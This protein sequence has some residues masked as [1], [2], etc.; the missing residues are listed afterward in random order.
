MKLL[1]IGNGGREHAL[2]WKLAQSPRVW[3]VYVAPGNAG[4]VR[5]HKLENIAITAIPD[6]I[7]FSRNENIAFT[8]VGPE[9]PLAE[10]IV[11]AY[12]AA[13]LKIFGPTQKAAQLE[14]SKRFAKDFMQR[15]NI[16]TAAYAT[17]TQAEAAHQYVDQQGTPIVIKASGL[18]AGKGVIVATTL[19][20][21]HAAINDILVEQRFGN[22][23]TEV[24]IEEFLQ[25]TEV[26]FIVMSD[27]QH[28]L[29]LATSQDH[30][31]LLDGDSG[32]NT[33]GMGAYSPTPFV[34][35][36]L[37]A[38]IMSKVIYPVI[39]GM[40]HEGALYT[41]FLYAGLMITPDKQIKVLEFNC[42]MGDPE[43]QPIMLRLKSDLSMLMERAF[44]GALD[45]TETEW[46]R[47]VALGV[48]MV[49]GGYPENPAKGD[50]IR[51]LAELV[52]E[53]DVAG[54][55]HIFHS[56]TTLDQNKEEQLITAGGRVL[57][58]TA[59][60]DNLK[61]AQQRAYELAA[62]IEF[63]GA[64]MRHDIGYQGISYLHKLV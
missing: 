45:Q 43:T 22:A 11:D 56:G 14:I 30:K 31:R 57:C 32:P 18:A 51:G 64:Y 42:R 55:F 13:G 10:G 3:K 15:H 1:V 50:V 36:S 46:D 16:P 21:A 54:D 49:A 27:G 60:G 33:G 20:T 17:F 35:P 53:Q 8:V 6:L 38:Q 5:E 4:T 37:H 28:V 12:Q 9:A 52:R 39:Q 7:R 41:G 44:D 62:R 48:V 34:S 58:V 40:A 26:S 24:I 19:E 63:K 25:G 47:R 59:L 2:A 61:M 29:P 23:G